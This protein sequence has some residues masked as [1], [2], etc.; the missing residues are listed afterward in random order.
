VVVVFHPSYEEVRRKPAPRSISGGAACGLREKDG[1]ALRHVALSLAAAGHGSRDGGRPNREPCVPES[2]FMAFEEAPAAAATDLA[3][4][5]L[6]SPYGRVTPAPSGTTGPGGRKSRP[7]DPF[8][9]HAGLFRLIASK[10]SGVP[11]WTRK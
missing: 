11:V 10:R 1:V 7:P 4:E 9:G 2:P 6:R 8:S 3:H 5:A